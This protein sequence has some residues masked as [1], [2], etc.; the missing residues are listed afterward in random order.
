[1][2]PMV[3]EAGDSDDTGYFEQWMACHKCG[4]TLD[5]QEAS[6]LFKKR[7]SEVGANNG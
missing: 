7:F 2:T 1:M 4:H 5:M 3:Y 6:E